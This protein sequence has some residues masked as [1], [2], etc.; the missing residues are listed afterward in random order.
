MNQSDRGIDFAGIRAGNP[1]ADT[2]NRFIE[3]K[4]RGSEYV[5]RCPFHNDKSP[6]FCIVPTK[7]KAFCMSCGWHGDVIDFVARFE[8][9][10]TAE[11]A[12]RLGGEPEA[13]QLPTS[14]PALPELPPDDAEAWTPV[15]P[16]PAHAPD[17]DPALTFNPRSHDRRTNT[18]GRV[19]DWSR[20]M[21]RRDAYRD[22]AGRI[23]GYVVRLEIDGQK[24]TPTVTWCRHEDGR[25][26]WCS[27]KFP[28][29]RPLQGL[30]ALAARPD[31][32]VLVVEGE[33]SRDAAAGS[34]GGFVAVT[35]PGGTNNI[36]K[37]GWTPL[38]S[39]SS[40]TLWPDADRPGRDAM[41]RLAARLHAAGVPVR[42]V[43]TMDMETEF[44]EGADIADMVA[45]GWTAAQIAAW[46]RPRASAYVPP[47]GPI[48]PDPS[49]SSKSAAPPGSDRGNRATAGDTVRA[50]PPSHETAT[51]DD[52]DATGEPMNAI[53]AGDWP[54]PI[55]LLGT[56][57][58]P[59][60]RAE[61]L[62]PQLV[63]YVF[64]QSE[65][66]GADPGVLAL[67]CIVACAA[68]IHDGIEIQ[69]KRHD[70]TWT[71]QARLWGAIVGDPSIRKTPAI[72][73]AV[74]H[75]RKIDM[76]LAE[77]SG[78]KLAEYER[79]LKIHKKREAAHINGE[80]RGNVVGDLADPPTPPASERLMAE[81]ITVEAMSNVLKDNA[82]GVL[83]IND[84]LSGWFGSMDA[85]KGGGGKDRGLWLEIYNGGPKRVDRV[86]RGTILVPNWSA[87]ILG[88]IQP[89]SIRR[90]SG[91]MYDDGL[92]QRFMVV[93]GKPVPG[94][95]QDRSPDMDAVKAYRGLLDELFATGPSER[96]V[97][98]SEGA[99][100]WREAIST[101]SHGL[102]QADMLTT[103][104]RSHLGKWD[105]LFARVLLVFHCIE[106]RSVG[107][108]PNAMPVT[109][110]TAKRVHD[111]LRHFLFPHAAA[112]YMGV[113]ARSDRDT[114]AEWLADWILADARETVTLRDVTQAYRRWRMLA[115]WQQKAVMRSL[116]D[117][118]W[119]LAEGET[120]ER[121]VNRWAVNPKVH[122]LFGKQAAAAKARKA[123]ARLRVRDAFAKPE[124]E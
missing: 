12:R 20:I 81:D 116:E 91:Q 111:F 15:L 57:E 22:A 45:A 29:P 71:E 114:A 76:K 51:R 118:G 67:S 97:K 106:A 105:G 124:D 102:A 107:K 74:G 112:F 53:P 100:R 19:V 2:I 59:C 40:V 89:D 64:D 109:E 25:E 44:G 49:P 35:W 68:A 88:G 90:I 120:T 77:V 33:K 13:R 113:M 27:A 55:N 30:D 95:S 18:F 50:T 82:R 87:S 62:P 41:A 39:R 69:P 103:S 11:A 6:S 21:T 101:F 72:K 65:L 54:E 9:I 3:I 83:V 16:A 86:M 56:F 7:E 80:A 47:A 119:L 110:H 23:L 60:V 79:E 1:I 42:I 73:K 85:Y 8:G 26:S 28:D 70:P 43:D 92:L 84:E 94:G 48:D 17:Y 63:N 4:R 61:W 31:A 96:P 5:A 66:L 58:P 123:E 52:D 37:A 117:A 98:L 122:D 121:R 14:R 93:C 24:L 104:F 46:A 108:Y 32:P 38:E 10:D 78:A 99:H 75:L 115:D 34:L 36:D